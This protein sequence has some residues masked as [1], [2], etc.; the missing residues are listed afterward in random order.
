MS[1]QRVE[2]KILLGTK[3]SYGLGALGK[4]FA[5]S[6]TATFLMF[7]YTDVAGISAAFVGTLFLVARAID[8]FTDP[9]MGMIVDNT[10]S[11][12][13]KFRPWILIG[14]IVNSFALLAVFYTHSFTGTTLYVYAALTYILWGVTYTIM[15]IPFWSM[16]PALSARRVEREKL[17]VWPRTFASIAGLIMGGTGLYL[18]AELGDGD[19]G[20]GF[21][22]LS[23]LVVISFI[24]SGLITFFKVKEKV[25]L[26]NQVQKFTLA[27]VKTSSFLT[28][29]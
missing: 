28:I 6:I 5:Y 26:G 4:D 9:I 10:R 12:F 17:V 29:S 20:K 15:D 24:L 18:V 16:I 8:A 2:D 13:G 23:V 14:T 27:D 19:Q 22:L 7:Y 1:E 3:V 11:K 21:F 25:V